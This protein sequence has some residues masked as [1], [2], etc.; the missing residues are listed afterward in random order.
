MK[1]RFF[2]FE[3]FPNWWCCVI[4]DEPDT[5]DGFSEEVKT[6]FQV[7]SR[8]Q[9]ISCSRYL[10]SRVIVLQVITL[11]IMTFLL[12]TEFTKDSVLNKLK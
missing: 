7:V 12:Q 6:H 3:V 5:W 9:E 11:K 1:L 2:D 8:M 4:G 10:E